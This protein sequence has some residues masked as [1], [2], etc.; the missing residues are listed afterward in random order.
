MNLINAQSIVALD[1]VEYKKAN[2][3]LTPQ[4]LERHE[5]TSVAVIFNL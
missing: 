3:R 2:Q 4:T 5:A 1:A